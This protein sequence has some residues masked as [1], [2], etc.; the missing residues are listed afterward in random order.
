MRVNPWWKSLRRL[1]VVALLALLVSLGFADGLGVAPELEAPIRAMAERTIEGN[2]AVTDQILHDHGFTRAHQE[3]VAGWST[4]RPVEKLATAARAFEDARTGGAEDFLA[5]LSRDLSKRS[6]TLAVDER[7]ATL[8]ARPVTALPVPARRTAPVNPAAIAADLH[9]AIDAMS[10]HLSL[11][12]HVP[13]R[14]V[15]EHVGYT[16]A[17]SLRI[18]QESTDAVDALR[19]AV[20]EAGDV[21]AQRKRVADLATFVAS[22]APSAKEHPHLAP[23]VGPWTGGPVG[24]IGQQRPVDPSPGPKPTPGPGAGGVSDRPT[25]TAGGGGTVPP[26]VERARPRAETPHLE[27]TRF[28]APPVPTLDPQ[29]RYHGGGLRRAMRLRG[30]VGRIGGVAFGGQAKAADGTDTTGLTLRYDST[31]NDGARVVVTCGGRTAVVP[32]AD[33]IAIPAATWSAQDGAELVTAFGHTVAPT[34]RCGHVYNYAR[35]LDGTLIGLR[36]L[37]ADM[38]GMSAMGYGDLFADGK[39]YVLGAGETEPSPTDVEHQRELVAAMRAALP[40]IQ[41]YVFSDAETSFTF[42]LGD[43]GTLEISGSPTYQLLRF[44]GSLEARVDRWFRVIEETYALDVKA[45]E[46]R[47]AQAQ[48]EVKAALSALQGDMV[49]NARSEALRSQARA[50]VADAERIL[51]ALL[52]EARNATRPLDAR[53]EALL[54][55]ELF[56]AAQRVD[57]LPAKD[58]PLATAKAIEPLNPIVYRAATSFARSAAFFRYVRAEHPAAWAAFAAQLPPVSQT[59]PQVELPT[60]VA[61]G[62]DSP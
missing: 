56:L 31:A 62:A 18:V 57:V 33:W 35:A 4:L 12:G 30:F 38:I 44:D 10:H 25:A 13:L 45:V 40:H 6:T 23:F 37:Q 43:G 29:T 1:A 47:L 54:Q 27:R 60:T 5:L 39:G 24:P 17:D 52:A 46:T 58:N 41:S 61:C 2:R 53:Q 48:A 51:L 20:A 55:V 14:E 28:T 9:P 34:I 49:A 36:L 59:E 42:S 32:A 3:A 26:W 15:I 50:D 16:A 19:R 11:G 8:L 21:K 22:K 7:L